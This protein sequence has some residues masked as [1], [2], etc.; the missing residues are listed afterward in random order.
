MRRR[1][2]FCPNC[3][4]LRARPLPPHKSSQ[5]AGLQYFTMHPMLVER[6]NSR[7]RVTAQL[8]T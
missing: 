1:L 2:L 7:L 4:F 6:L 8:C 3:S 5:A